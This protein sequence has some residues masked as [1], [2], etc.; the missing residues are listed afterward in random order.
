MIIPLIMPDKVSGMMILNKMM[1]YT[2][3]QGHLAASMTV[4]YDSC[5]GVVNWQH[6]KR[7]KIVDHTK[8]NGS[9]VYLMHF[10]TVPNP[11]T[12]EDCS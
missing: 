11:E 6:H 1:V 4:I 8:Y 2:S 5:H 12:C 3:H 9:L 7:K 10:D